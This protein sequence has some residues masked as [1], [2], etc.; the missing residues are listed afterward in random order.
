M[1]FLTTIWDM[2]NVIYTEGVDGFKLSPT[3]RLITNILRC[4]DNANMS[5]Y[6]PYWILFDNVSYIESIM[7]YSHLNDI[8]YS[9]SLECFVFNNI[10]HSI[11][12][13]NAIYTILHSENE[14]DEFVNQ[15]LHIIRSVY[16]MVNLENEMNTMCKNINKNFTL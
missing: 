8:R 10:I 2:F 1:L 5:V 16:S 7:Q 9:K 15:R 3:Y 11:I 6:V 13:M 14:T 4:P 12:G